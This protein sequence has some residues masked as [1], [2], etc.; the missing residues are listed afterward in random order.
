MDSFTELKQ[1]ILSLKKEMEI[2]KRDV[3]INKSKNSTL[4]IQNEI[5]NEEL[6]NTT[7]F[8]NNNIEILKNIIK[9]YEEK[10]NVKWRIFINIHYQGIA[11]TFRCYHDVYSSDS[12]ENIKNYILDKKGFKPELTSLHCNGIEVKSGKL[13]NNGI[14]D[15]STITVSVNN[16]FFF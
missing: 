1:E 7:V 9:E 15:G 14:R 2:I 11:E 5:L 12:I 3:V 13:Y 16:G 4:T 6:K 10:Q 8:F